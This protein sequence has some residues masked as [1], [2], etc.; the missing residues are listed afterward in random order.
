[1]LGYST[2]KGGRGWRLNRKYKSTMPVWFTSGATTKVMK[3]HVKGY[4]ADYSSYIT[5]MLHYDA[6]DLKNNN[7]PKSITKIILSSLE[8]VTNESKEVYVST[9]C[10]L[11]ASKGVWGKPFLDCKMHFT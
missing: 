8:S 10:M 11:V 4:M 1:M 9:M 2:E 7:S 5:T 3:Q 6:D